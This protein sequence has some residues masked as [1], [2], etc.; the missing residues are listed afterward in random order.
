MTE[1]YRLAE[2]GDSAELLALILGAYQTIRDLNIAFTAAQ[3]DLDLVRSNIVNHSCYVLELDGE[4][5]ATIS[6]KSLEEVT[7]HPFLY[8]F[9]VD[10]K[11]KGRGVGRR[12][13]DHVEDTVV[14]QGLQASAVTLA[15]SRKHP[16]LLPMYERRG[17]R[18]FYERD[19]GT[20]DKLVFMT[21]ELPG[22][23]EQADDEAA[24]ALLQEGRTA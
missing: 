17:Y 8:W 11:H 2:P 10:P 1:V 24:A 22:K 23:T 7:P 5:A 18:P 19:L 9:A 4:I 15:T 6:L 21:K 12:L 14:R 13:L 20:D 16:W 3:A